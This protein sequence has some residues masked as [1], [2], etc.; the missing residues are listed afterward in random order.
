MATCRH[1]PSASIGKV[2]LVEDDELFG[3]GLKLKLER[4]RVDCDWFG[5][6]DS[7]V[8]ALSQITYHAVIA[9]IF[10][11][12]DRPAGLE[13]VKL[14]KERGIPSIIITSRLDMAIAKQ[15]LNNGADFLLE[16]PFKIGD[17]IRILQEIW[18]NPRGLIGRRERYLEM[19]NLTEKEKEIARLVI[20]GLTNQEVA[21]ASA[22]SLATVKFYTNQ[23][24]EKCVVHSRAELFNTI[25]PT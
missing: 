13:I 6:F 1:T 12:T 3:L 19:Q 2:L 9:D 11:N 24:F 4:S 14:A 8:S 7:S 21:N 25:F 17:L 23:I 22:V 5:E 10:L 15:G 18:E 20:K 16:K